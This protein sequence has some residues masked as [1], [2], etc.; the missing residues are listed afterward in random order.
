MQIERDFEVRVRAALSECHRLG[1]HPRDFEEMLNNTSAVRLAERLVI[2]G[3]LQS[4]LR[5][6]AQMGRLDLSVESIMLEVQFEPLFDKKFR[7]AA[8]WHLDQVSP[9]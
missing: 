7:D 9:H 8:Q 3:N 4:G 1:Y 5:R 2:S 6:L